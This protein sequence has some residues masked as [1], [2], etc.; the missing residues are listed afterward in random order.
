[1]HVKLH[2]TL[3][4]SYFHE[5]VLTNVPVYDGTREYRVIFF[6]NMKFTPL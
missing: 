5:V 1:M 3:W 2:E 4:E 6:R